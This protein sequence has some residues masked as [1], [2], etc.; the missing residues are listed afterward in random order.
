MPQ[1]SLP[2]KLYKDFKILVVDNASSDGSVEYMQNNYPEIELISL[3]ENY[4]FSKAV[5]VGI[6]HS[7]TSINVNPLN[8]DTTVDSHYN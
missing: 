6:K 7:D 5:N 2:S 3:S 4:G 1:V 8:N